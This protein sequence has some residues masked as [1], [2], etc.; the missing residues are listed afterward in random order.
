MNT[1]STII[2]ALTALGLVT[3]SPAQAHEARVAASCEE[4]VRLNLAGFVADRPSTV[5]V[6]LNGNEQGPVVFTGQTVRTFGLPPAAGRVEVTVWWRASEANGH[7]G[8]LW[9]RFDLSCGAPAPP[10]EPPAP[11]APP[12][13]PAPPSPALPAPPASCVFQMARVVTVHTMRV[14]VSKASVYSGARLVGRTTLAQPLNSLKVRVSLRGLPRRYGVRV[15]VRA[16]DGWHV[17]RRT[18]DRCG[19]PIATVDP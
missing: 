12:P 13:P 7:Q 1:R 14:R 5:H 16:S 10:P 3:A 15:V 17:Y 11:P 18:W 9:K 19:G 6:S 8:D 4:G 2:S